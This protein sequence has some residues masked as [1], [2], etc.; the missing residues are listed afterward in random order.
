MVSSVF[1]NSYIIK[2]VG[3]LNLIYKGKNMT[4]EEFVP[5]AIRTESKNGSLNEEAKE[6]GLTD[7]IVHSFMGIA[8][9]VYEYD[10]ATVKKDAV[11]A[12]EELGDMLWYLA[13]LKDELDF[14]IPN[15]GELFNDLGFVFDMTGLDLVKKSMF[16][17]KSLDHNK[18]KLVCTQLYK[19]VNGAI[20][21]HGGNPEHVMDVIIV[22]LK[23]RYG[24]A[25]SDDRAENREL[26]V[27]RAILE[28]GL[29]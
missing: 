14:I 6:R 24:E 16:Y 11:N 29:K 5:L 7:R 9:E 13:V 8:T 25:F 20:R 1:F 4:F 3:I 17:N 23:A 18:L 27:E 2:I 10:L 26:G 21:L 28:D 15:D 12:L 22:K 19:E